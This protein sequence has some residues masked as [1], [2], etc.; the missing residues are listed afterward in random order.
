[1]SGFSVKC[2]GVGDG[3][4]CVDRHHAAF[5]YRLGNISLLLDCGEPVGDSLASGGV[6][7]DA[8]DS[9]FLS[10]L[11]SDHVG[12]L[13]MLLQGWWLKR[14]NKKLTIHMPAEGVRPVSQMLKASYLFPELFRF[15]LSFEEL[16]VGR[17]VDVKGVRVTPYSTSHL[18]GLKRRF[19]GKYRQGFKA[20]CFLIET[21]R[22]RIGH[23]AD[24]G[25]PE[26]LEPLL[27][28]PLDLLVCELAHFTPAELFRYLEGR[29]IRRIVFVH[30]AARHWKKL[31]ALRLLAVKMLPGIDCRFAS[32]AQQ[33]SF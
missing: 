29:D 8:I 15:R 22:R 13:P 21:G 28:Q 20:Y 24:L 27:K 11:H 26:D 4:P 12:G 18:D 31:G 5:W 9:V 7:P 2:F 23:S 6:A 25:R 17:S 32:D 16:R 33:F 14:R 10:H 3:W 30:L 1:M 19:G